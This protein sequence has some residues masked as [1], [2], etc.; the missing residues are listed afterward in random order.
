M[1]DLD[2]FVEPDFD[3]PNDGAAWGQPD[4]ADDADPD[5]DL[6]PHADTGPKLDPA[7]AFGS[8]PE[9]V[10]YLAGAYRRNLDGNHRTWC[11]QWWRHPEAIARLDAL[12]RSFEHLRQEPALGP[13]VWWRDH[14]E[15]HMRVLMDKDDGPLR[16]CTPDAH[17]DRPKPL[18]VTRPHPDLF[19]S[20]H[21]RAH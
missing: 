18:P 10:E 19:G 1:S 2:A 5:A 4:F 15:P 8:L 13:S 20:G 3:D 21:A 12:W 16:Y 7:M 6:E 11:A 9:F 14:V 17:T